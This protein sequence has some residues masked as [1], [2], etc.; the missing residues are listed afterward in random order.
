[1][2][3]VETT[4]FFINN[5]TKTSPSHSASFKKAAKLV[6]V[7]FGD[8]CRLNSLVE[9]VSF[10]SFIFGKLQ[11]TNGPGKSVEALFLNKVFLFD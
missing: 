5:P 9:H 8:L 3:M 2:L 7:A 4:N 6:V 1:M 10:Q 11:A